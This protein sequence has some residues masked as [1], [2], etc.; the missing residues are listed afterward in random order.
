MKHMNL[1][2]ATAHDPSKLGPARP[3][4]PASSQLLA[5]FLV[6]ILLSA[7]GGSGGG[8]GDGDSTAPTAR[9]LFPP[10][11]GMTDAETITVT[12]T[13]ADA[14]TVTVVRVNGVDATSADG[15]ASWRAVVPLVSGANALVVE[16][17]DQAGNMDMNA[18]GANLLNQPIYT[19]PWNLAFDAAGNRLLMT[20]RISRSLIGIDLADGSRDKIS[21]RA[22]AVSRPEALTY[23]VAGDRVIVFAD[24]D[25]RLYSIDLATGAYTLFSG[26][27][28]GSGTL[29]GSDIRALD[30]DD[31]LGAGMERVL[32]VEGSAQRIFAVDLASGDRSI[33]SEDGVAGM[34]DPFAWPKSIAVDSAN[35]RALVG[36]DVGGDGNIFAVDLTSG[37]RSI[38]SPDDGNY[39]SFID[40]AVDSAND[41]LYGL[42]EGFRQIVKIDVGN[43]V[44]QGQRTTL[45]G[46]GTGSGPEFFIPVAMAL[47]TAG[48]RL[49]VA[50]DGLD[51][52]FA[53][54]LAT[55]ERTIVDDND[56]GSGIAYNP[57]L[58]EIE[59]NPESDQV[60][61]YD[62][63]RILRVGLDSGVR[64]IVT[65]DADIQGKQVGGNAAGIAIDLENNRMLV[66]TANPGTGIN[67]LIGADLTTG[68]RSVIA[69]PSPAAHQ[70]SSIIRDTTMDRAITVITTLNN[71]RLNQIDL[72]LGVDSVFSGSP[73]P[74][75]MPVGAGDDFQFIP[76]GGIALDVANDR[77]LVM[78]DWGSFFRMFAVDLPT[79]DRSLAIQGN[80]APEFGNILGKMVLDTT[81]NRL[82]ILDERNEIVDLPAVVTLDLGDESKAILSNADIGEGVE[83]KTPKD[84]AFHP[85]RDLA[86][87]LDRGLNALVAVDLES[88]DRVIF[89]K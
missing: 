16:T 3:A 35:N 86:V 51:A 14:G 38:I 58:V 73:S 81:R 66:A 62:R 46:N 2:F 27:G 33:F 48:N 34:G 57:S 45:S 19:S 12:G 50:D 80:E 4:G 83:F 56:F 87:V 22:D 6:A 30:Y 26:S 7:C 52:V 44:N 40:L 53:V 54:D 76:L 37:D 42:E 25:N 11:Q 67:R 79:G 8:S 85:G 70:V 89:S 75:G 43:G 29:F 23:D 39:A 20:D 24:G 77:V 32:V 78:Q 55:G 28:A 60:Y 41:T 72:A 21:G 36:D 61:V 1:E 59:L 64:A 65:D 84:I 9:I 15:F 10:A 5:C 69:D 71:P 49:L 82:L 74:G 68:V 63:D 13:A 31:S 18:A 88:G 47:D 17:R